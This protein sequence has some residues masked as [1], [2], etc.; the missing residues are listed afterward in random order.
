MELEFFISFHPAS[1]KS[2][3][4]WKTWIH[5]L[6]LLTSF[7]INL[8][9]IVKKNLQPQN[10]HFYMISGNIQLK[11]LNP[12]ISPNRYPQRNKFNKKFSISIKESAIKKKKHN[13]LYVPLLLL[14]VISFYSTH[15]R[16]IKKYKIKKYFLVEGEIFLCIH[17]VGI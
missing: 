12:S 17:I 6:H 9:K 2:C 11:N 4:T 3:I 8:W 10:L 7:S 14:H 5:R 13:F 1:W 16:L 15:S